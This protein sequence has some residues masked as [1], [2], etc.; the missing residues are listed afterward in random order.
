MGLFY[1]S[2]IVGLFFTIL[3]MGLVLTTA[4]ILVTK[5]DGVFVWIAG[6][7]ITVGPFYIILKTKYPDKLKQLNQELSFKN[8]NGK[9]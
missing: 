8:K 1:K 2:L 6:P 5:Y 3:S 9:V 4:L 7:L